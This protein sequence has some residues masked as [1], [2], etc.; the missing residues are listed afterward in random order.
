MAAEKQLINDL[1]DYADDC[2]LM[3]Y[4]YAVE[5]EMAVLDACDVLT[6]YTEKLNKLIENN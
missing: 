5:A 6:D 2:E 1:L 4:A 3:A